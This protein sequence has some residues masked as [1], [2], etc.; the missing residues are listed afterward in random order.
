VYCRR[1]APHHLGACRGTA[2]AHAWKR[3]DLTPV[4]QPVS[5]GGKFIFYNGS[6]GRLHVI[7]L[8]ART[9]R[10]AW[11]LLA[12]ISDVT[13]GV[14]PSLDV[15]GLRV[16]A[17][18]SRSAK[19]PA[20]VVA[21]IDAR[22]GTVIWTSA[23]GQF[24]STPGPCPGEPKVVCA[25]GTLTGG[26]PAEGLRFDVA[27]GI[28]LA[29]VAVDGPGVRDIGGGLLDPG[30]RKPD[31]LVA[32]HGSAISWRVPL[33]RI[34]GAGSSTDT[35]WNFER[36]EKLGLF[37]G[38]V[39][40]TPLKLTPTYGIIDLSRQMTAGFRISDG[41]V[42]WRNRGAIFA[43]GPLPCPGFPLAG[44]SNQTDTATARPPVGLRLRMTGTLKETFTAKVTASP[45][46][47][48][49]IEGFDPASGRTL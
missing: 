21:A 45:A 40:Y 35:G 14:A 46:A 5:V 15:S 2:T 27:T 9:G 31:F 23:P 41:A 10:T 11:S 26:Q 8:D 4:T 25:T 1:G 38:S 34:F 43:C 18:L 33:A 22:T 13:P 36:F 7:A 17:L 49:T 12:S 24:S 48:V 6:Q 39:G 29:P 16:I 37:V 19:P 44:Y 47:T 20:A 32:V 28:R 3:A 30:L 42:V